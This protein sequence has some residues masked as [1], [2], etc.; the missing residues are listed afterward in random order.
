MRRKRRWIAHLWRLGV[1]AQEA[2]DAAGEV[3][4]AALVPWQRL[5]ARIEPHYPK[6]GRGR[7]PYALSVMLRVH[8]VQLCY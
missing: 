1:Y 5:E 4:G 2:Q 6:A 3:F 7:R 8:L